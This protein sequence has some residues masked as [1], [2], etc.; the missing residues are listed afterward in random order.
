[1]KAKIL[2]WSILFGLFLID[3]LMPSPTSA[4]TGFATALDDIFT[5]LVSGGP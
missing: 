1:M 2:T 5:R 4:S 3:L